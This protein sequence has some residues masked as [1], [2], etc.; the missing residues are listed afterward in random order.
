MTLLPCLQLDEGEAGSRV[1]VYDANSKA[2]IQR[3]GSGTTAR[4][5]SR[6]EAPSAICVPA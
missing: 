1:R 2:V 4:L 3:G 5:R 6:R